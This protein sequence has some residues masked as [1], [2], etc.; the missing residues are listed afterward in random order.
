M[1]IKV[2]VLSLFILQSWSSAFA[3]ETNMPLVKPHR[4]F[5]SFQSGALLGEKDKGT[6]FTFSMVHGVRLNTIGIGVGV[7][8]DS[9]PR[10]KTVPLSFVFSLDLFKVK[11]NS[12]Y[13]M[14]AVG[15]ARAWHRQQFVYEP[16]YNADGGFSFGPTAGYRIKADRY[17]LYLSAGYRFQRINYTYSGFYYGP[18]EYRVEEDVQRAVIQIGFGLN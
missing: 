13:L 3:Q 6:S 5:N 10:W 12:G 2:A 11:E 18:S 14:V 7:G 17:N 4:Y 9:Y 16:T 15:H 8:F 1:R